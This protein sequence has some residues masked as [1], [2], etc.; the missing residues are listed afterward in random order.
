[1]P[2]IARVTDEHRGTCSHGAPC[3]PHSV[4]GTITSG[5]PDTHA[6]GLDVARL[7]DSVIHDCPHCGTGY[8]AS[9]SGTVTANGLGVARLGDTVIYPGGSGTTTTASGDVKADG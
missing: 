9:A 2:G 6:D 3:C 4:I 1:M 5:S 7:N 8:I